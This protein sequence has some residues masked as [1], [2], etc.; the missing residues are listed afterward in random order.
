[1]AGRAPR[2]DKIRQLWYA[3]P[4]TQF[5]VW[6]W[7][8]LNVAW[9]SARRSTNLIVTERNE[10]LHNT[11]Q[12]N[13]VECR[14]VTVQ[15]S[16]VRACR[17]METGPFIW[18][19]LEQVPEMTRPYSVLTEQYRFGGKPVTGRSQPLLALFCFA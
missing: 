1:M 17:E 11:M 18:P 15:S 9:L 13:Q 19:T 3:G 2:F 8:Q 14:A 4:N 7:S 12:R 10:C 5:L 16:G 6:H